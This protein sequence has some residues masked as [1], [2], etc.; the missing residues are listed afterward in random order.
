M[1][2]DAPLSE[3]L[4]PGQD[5]SSYEDSNS[6]PKNLPG[7]NVDNDPGGG[8]PSS[9]TGTVGDLPPDESLSQNRGERSVDIGEEILFHF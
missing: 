2:G 8:D 6:K 1:P 3:G 9:Q 4:A 5:S 7:E